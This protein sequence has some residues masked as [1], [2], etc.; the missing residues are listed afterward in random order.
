MLMR[1]FL[2]SSTSPADSYDNYVAGLH[3][4][5][6]FR[7]LDHLGEHDSPRHDPKF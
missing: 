2:L 3:G 6:S 4:V 7:S 1:R 5:R